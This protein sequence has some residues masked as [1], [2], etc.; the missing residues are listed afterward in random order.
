MVIAV[1]IEKRLAIARAMGVSMLLNPFKIDV[2][3]E[4][5]T[6]T[7]HGCDFA[8][9]CVGKVD[10]KQNPQAMKQAYDLGLGLK[11]SQL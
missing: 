3:M 9:E 6:A 7:E 11:S 4:V 1:D 8:F 10:V 2:G 5:L